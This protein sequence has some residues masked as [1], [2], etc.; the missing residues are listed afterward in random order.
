M[1]KAEVTRVLNG[2][3]AQ[4]LLRSSIPV[5]LAYTGLD[6]FPR[7]VPLGYLWDGERFVICTIPGA[8]KVPALK[9]NPNVAMT[10]DTESFPPHI[11]LVRGTATLRVVD[12]VPPEYLAA[13]KKQIGAEGMPAFEAEVREMYD[14]MVRIEVEPR[15]AKVIDFQTTLPSALERLARKKE[16]AAR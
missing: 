7:V 1:E 11:L 4:E 9:A 2:R 12:G 14:Q 15:W 8:P 13:S 16:A 10:I 6:G 3:I 5:R